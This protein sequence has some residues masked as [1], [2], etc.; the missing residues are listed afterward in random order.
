LLNPFKELK[1]SFIVQ[2]LLDDGF[3]EIDGP[4]QCQ[5]KDC[6]E[7]VP[8]GLYSETARVVTWKCSHGHISRMENT[9]I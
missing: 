8:T 1:D 7:A 5:T 6:K 3:E 9:T 2:K 4:L